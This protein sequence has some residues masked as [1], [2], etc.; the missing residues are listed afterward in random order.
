MARRHGYG[1]PLVIV[2]G[3]LSVGES[4][5]GVAEVLPTPPPRR[6]EGGIAAY[7]GLILY[8]GGDCNDRDASAAFDDLEAFDPKTD[9][10]KSLAKAPIG[11]HGPG[12]TAVG[13]AVY[14][15]GGNSRCLNSPS[16]TVYTFRLLSAPANAACGVSL[17]EMN[18]LAG[19]TDFR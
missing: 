2:H 16:N 10:W 14:F 13:D 15:I 8:F 19:G 1:P 6:S 18:S 17:W 7:H 4:F 12:T 5:K 3:S 9:S 11:L